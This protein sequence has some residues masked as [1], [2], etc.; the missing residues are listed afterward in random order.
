MSQEFYD[1]EKVLRELHLEEDEL[2]R[3]VSEGEMRAFRDG[4]KMKFK[5]EDI[6]RFRS[7][8]DESQ[9]VIEALDSSSSGSSSSPTV[10]AVEELPDE[11]IFEDDD[12]QDVGMATE[13][14]DDSFLEDDENVEILIEDA[15]GVGARSGRRSSG[16]RS[17]ARGKSGSGVR[18]QLK[19]GRSTAR[20]VAQPEQEDSALW[21]GV[22]VFTA[23]ILFFAVL[24][25]LDAAKSLR[26]EP[27]PLTSWIANLVRDTFFSS[28]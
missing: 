2:K 12:D 25:I 13:A 20:G 15:S 27:T 4:E 22:F 23:I 26:A 21:K 11:L 1:F 17:S 10:E 24:T 5:A 9:D 7:R 16:G 19:R 3:L 8:V 28:N 14:I 18:S 6:E